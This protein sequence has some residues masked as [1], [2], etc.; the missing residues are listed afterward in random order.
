MEVWP[1][2]APDSILER[3]SSPEERESSLLTS[4]AARSISFRRVASSGSLA[5][6]SMLVR[7]ALSGVLS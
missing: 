3:S 1:P 5:A 4:T 2:D 7:S 6:S